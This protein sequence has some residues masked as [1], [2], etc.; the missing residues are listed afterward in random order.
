MYLLS[1]YLRSFEGH[2]GQIS[3]F[4]IAV[5]QFPPYQPPQQ[6]SLTVGTS[7][8]PIRISLFGNC[9]GT[10]LNILTRVFSKF[11]ASDRLQLVSN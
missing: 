5:E 3:E 2:T 9:A 1:G 10:I 11:N 4:S 6:F 7:Q 8:K